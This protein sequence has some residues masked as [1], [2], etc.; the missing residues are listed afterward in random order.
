MS[1][2]SVPSKEVRQL[3]FKR[4]INAA[5]VSDTRSDFDKNVNV[6]KFR[7]DYFSE[8]S[9]YI[10]NNPGYRIRS[11]QLRT[12]EEVLLLIREDFKNYLLNK[13]SQNQVSEIPDNFNIYHFSHFNVISD[14]FIVETQMLNVS[15]KNANDEHVMSLGY[16][17]MYLADNVT[18]NKIFIG[19]IKMEK[20][21]NAPALR[22]EATMII[23]PFN[24]IVE[25]VGKQSLVSFFVGKTFTGLRDNLLK[26]AKRYQVKIMGISHVSKLSP[27]SRHKRVVNDIKSLS[28]SLIDVIQLANINK[29]LY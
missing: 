28:P 6:E 1:S 17:F 3:M 27:S 22:L 13:V 24:D 11:E 14:D 25:H 8:G 10:K 4:I 15:C 5:I 12:N 18:G 29:H 2:I 16:G 7:E 23:D 9:E 20:G 26:S 21:F 19:S